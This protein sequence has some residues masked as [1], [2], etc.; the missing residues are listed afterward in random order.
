VCAALAFAIQAVNAVAFH[1]VG[2][3]RRLLTQLLKS[4]RE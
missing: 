1:I 4:W 2:I 3:L